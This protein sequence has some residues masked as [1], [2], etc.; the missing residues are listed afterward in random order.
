MRIGCIVQARMGSSRLPGKVCAE[1][2]GKPLLAYAFERLSRV[3][4]LDFFVAATSSGPGDDPVRELCA[5]Y[6]A[7]CFSGP[8]ENVALRFLEALEA[9][10]CDAFVRYCADSPLL[11]VALLERGISLFRKSAPDVCSNVHPR[12]F[13][14]GQSVEVVGAAVFREAFP[15]M[16]GDELEHVTPYFYRNAA[17][18]RIVNFESGG[19]SSG[20]RLCVDDREDFERIE[21][22]VSRM[23]RPHWEYGWRELAA[24]GQGGARP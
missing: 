12:T 13:P 5:G 9:H 24:L 3:S 23:T 18:Y 10:P 8:H 17:Q 11:D 15:R 21:G 22:I 20:T 16:A 19:S 7:P 4:G 2:N 6:G 14:P 1:I